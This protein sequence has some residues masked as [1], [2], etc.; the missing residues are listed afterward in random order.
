MPKKQ[1]TYRKTILFGVLSVLLITLLFGV[2]LVFSSAYFREK[3]NKEI[4]NAILNKCIQET[5]STL[6]SLDQMVTEFLLDNS[7]IN[8]YM[9]TKEIERLEEYKMKQ[10]LNRFNNSLNYYYGEDVSLYLFAP[11][12]DRIYLNGA[13]YQYSRFGH[14]DW[15]NQFSPPQ[16]TDDWQRK[17]NILIYGGYE[18]FLPFDGFIK[19][20]HYPLSVSTSYGSASVLIPDHVLI[21]YLES[22]LPTEASQIYVLDPRNELLYA[23]GRDYTDYYE[24]VLKKKDSKRLF[25]WPSSPS[26]Y[27]HTSPYTGWQYV[28]R[29][30]KLGIYSLW[31]PL[32]TFYAL[33]VLIYCAG[34]SIYLAFLFGKPYLFIRQMIQLMKGTIPKAQRIE[35]DEFLELRTGFVDLNNSIGTLRTQLDAYRF[36]VCN[37]LILD[38]ITSERITSYEEHEQKMRQAGLK[39]YSKNYCALLI[40]REDGSRISSDQVLEKI[41]PLRDDTI[42][43]LCT[44]ANVRNVLLLMTSDVL[45]DETI[46]NQYLNQLL[47]QFEEERIILGKGSVC[48]FPQELVSSYENALLSVQYGIAHKLCGI[49]EYKT[50]SEET[51][52]TALGERIVQ[53]ID[54]NYDNPDFSL[55]MMEGYFSM[56]ASHMA[57]V[58]KEHTGETIQGYLTRL[59]VERA[60]QLMQENSREPLERIAEQVGYVNTQALNRA[61]KKIRGMPPRTSSKVHDGTGG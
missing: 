12:S 50:A 47:E 54:N 21:R 24:E 37:K 20:Y 15:V 8:Q 45:L 32:G 43:F 55:N 2:V 29:I 1:R 26:F 18:S 57:R 60:E 48:Q 13:L 51:R 19:S 28:L 25:Q 56:T 22:S 61:F 5:D 40:C 44:Q 46:V 3:E 58:F 16:R 14:E 49:V 34:V 17:E 9:V 4:S 10:S 52:K 41:A 38:L 35:A 39:F 31:S 6:S 23:S 27:S 7:H 30:P 53:F 36:E 59:R 33:L 42:C 11:K